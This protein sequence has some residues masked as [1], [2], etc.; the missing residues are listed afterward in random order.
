MKEI[1]SP[2]LFQKEMERLR[3]R[4]KRIGFVP[5]MGALHEGHLSLV[6]AARREN[7]VVA[8]SIFVNPFQFGP[9]EDLKKY[10]RPIAKDRR[11]LRLAKIDYL[12]RPSAD[13]MYPKGFSSVVETGIPGSIR[14]EGSVFSGL[15]GKLCGRPRPGHFRGVAT[16]VAKLLNV[17]KPHRADC[18]EKD[19]QQSV[20]VRRLVEDLN[21]DVEMRLRPTVREKDGLAMS[22]RN[23]YLVADERCRAK[24]LSE[25][26]FWVREQI[27]SGRRDLRRLVRAAKARLRSRTT[28][29]DYF[30]IVDPD[31]LE[32][33]KAV[34]PRMRVVTACYV[35]KTR[36]IDNCEIKIPR[37]A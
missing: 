17:V 36:L 31:T 21:L 6:R 15:A 18:G 35:G 34:C 37:R 25:T 7:D 4:G 22:S 13:Q 26:I 10:P 2:K 33:L 32:G 28:K 29:I 24:A 30:E 27:R 9:R 19:Y 12:F 8:V 20:I 23:Q 11:L 3:R 16:V 5:T 1:R 14:G